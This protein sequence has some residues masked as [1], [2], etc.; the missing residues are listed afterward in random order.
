MTSPLRAGSGSQPRLSSVRSVVGLY[1]RGDLDVGDLPRVLAQRRH[2]VALHT[3][4]LI[5]VMLELDVVPTD[6]TQELGGGA[7]RRQ[8]VRPV[9]EGVDR[10]DHNLCADRFRLLRG[11]RDVARGSVELLVAVQARPL[12][13]YQGVQ[14]LAAQPLREVQRYRHVVAE[15]LPGVG[16]CC[17]VPDRG[18]REDVEVIVGALGGGRCR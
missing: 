12:E 2:Q 6:A 13:A 14:P 16:V 10:F 7:G 4:H 9:L 17:L 15:A 11:P 3:L 5:R 18:A 1:S 8:Q